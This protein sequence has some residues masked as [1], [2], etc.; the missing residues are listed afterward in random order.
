[1]IQ[2]KEIALSNLLFVC[3]SVLSNEMFHQD[4]EAHQD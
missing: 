4:F 1:M 3:N 2:K